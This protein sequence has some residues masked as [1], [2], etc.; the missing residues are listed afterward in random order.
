MRHCQSIFFFSKFTFPQ[1]Y[2]WTVNSIRF[3]PV[4]RS[5]SKIWFPW[6]WTSS[7][8]NTYRTTTSDL[9]TSLMS[10]VYENKS[11]RPNT[12]TILHSLAH[13][14][15]QLYQFLKTKVNKMLRR[16]YLFILRHTQPS[17][18]PHLFTIISRTTQ[19]LEPLVV[20]SNAPEPSSAFLFKNHT[21]Y[22]YWD[23]QTASHSSFLVG[24]ACHSHTST[25][26]DERPAV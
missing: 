4:T 24:N 7:C 17:K 16:C 10:A 9:S 13:L 21:L 20:L 1:P 12:W 5:A 22:L 2:R 11:C 23:K 15:Q 18:V 8:S 3:V 19:C 25:D 14:R 26:I 6:L